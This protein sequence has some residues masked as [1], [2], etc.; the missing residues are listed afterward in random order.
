MAQTDI[1]KPETNALA[2]IKGYLAN[3]QIKQ[4]FSDILGERA[5]AFTNSIINVVKNNTMLQKAAPDSV[6]NSALV[7]ATLNLPID[8]SLGYA[9]VVPY[10]LR[11]GGVTATFQIMYKGIIQLCIRSGQ[12]AKIHN[13]EIYRDELKTYNPTTGDI[14]FNDPATF[15]M[16]YQ[17]DTKNIAG[18][19]SFFRLKSGFECSNYISIEEAMAHGKRFSKS[20]QYDLKENKKSSLWSTDII[21]MGKKTSLKM[22]LS[23][24]GIMSIEM[25]DAFVTESEDFDDALTAANDKI[26]DDAGTRVIDTDFD[27]APQLAAAETAEPQSA[28]DWMK[29]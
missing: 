17:G 29:D 20:Y 1:Q 13:T 11:N 16:R 10:N 7:A 5:G 24:Y 28:N 6:I 19:Y 4:R 23:K 27:P 25:Q 18:F 2:Q 22:L 12:Y 3:P 21:S 26:S 9:A 14:V 8:P 15:K